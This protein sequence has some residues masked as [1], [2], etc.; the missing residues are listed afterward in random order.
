[1]DPQTLRQQ[2]IHYV[3]K[4][5]LTYSAEHVRDAGGFFTHSLGRDRTG[6]HQGSPALRGYRGGFPG[7]VV[8]ASEDGGGGPGGHDGPPTLGVVR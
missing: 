5:S 4:L 3:C 7:L 2:G 1:M 6:I 8:H